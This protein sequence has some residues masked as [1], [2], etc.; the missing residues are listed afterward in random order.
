MFKNISNSIKPQVFVHLYTLVTPHGSKIS[1]T[2]LAQVGEM[3]PKG[4]GCSSQH[5]KKDKA[6]LGTK[7]CAHT[8]V[9]NEEEAVLSKILGGKSISK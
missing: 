2:H 8:N 5:R 3:S 9:R 4:R 6:K 1:A 7:L